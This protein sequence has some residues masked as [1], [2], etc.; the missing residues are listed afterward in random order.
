MMQAAEGSLSV[1]APEYESTLAQINSITQKA[2]DFLNTKGL[3]AFI[4]SLLHN[5]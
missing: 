1:R 4:S 2:T 5:L 3:D